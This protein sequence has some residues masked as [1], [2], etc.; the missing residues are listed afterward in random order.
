MEK[1]QAKTWGSFKNNELFELVNL[2][3]IKKTFDKK[4]DISTRKTK[5]FSLP[6]I[7]A[8][9]G[10]NGI[11]YYGRLEDWESEEMTLDVVNDGAISTGMVYA[12]PQRTGTLYN[13][14]QIKLK[15]KIPTYRQLLFLKQCLQT[16]IQLKFN[17]YNKATWKNKVENESIQL[18]LKKCSKTSYS[19]EDIDW[20]YMESFI[21]E[22]EAERIQELEAYLISTGLNDYRLSN[23]DK[24]LLTYQPKFGSFTLASSYIMRKKLVEVDD[25]GLFN[26]V[27]TKKKINA[28]SVN[29][30][31]KHPYVARGEQNN[32][33]RGYI[34]FDENY[35]NSGN[36]ISFGQDTATMY[37]QP[38]PY[39]TGDKI[40]IFNLNE[41]YGDLDENIAMYLITALN[42]TFANFT[43][44][45]QSF[46]LET[47][48][49]LSV[50][51]PVTDDGN[52]NF[53]YMKSYVNVVKKIAIEDVVKYKDN[54]ISLTKKVV[55]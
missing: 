5:D 12:Q 27:P 20:E 21:Q 44:G 32:G 28:N 47:I 17:Y 14:Y 37:Y 8:K 41:Q 51:L 23:K 40:Q 42:K 6:L 39:F 38:N 26:I 16:N 11:M 9:A 15:N 50:E 33:I 46:A 55:R 1:L 48:A 29:F 3:R 30:D 31:G 34:D 25:K 52:I 49:L 36:T 43:W 22:L 13:A 4:N 54:V 45:Q 18:P 24:D 10:N 7:N 35:L 2:K 53:E 19:Q